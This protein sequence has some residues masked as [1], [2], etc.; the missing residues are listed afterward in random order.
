MNIDSLAFSLRSIISGLHKTLRK[1]MPLDT[2]L[3]LT[4]LETIGLISR[5]G[6]ML[7]SELALHTKIT[8]PSMS[9]ILKKMEKGG[10]IQKKS[11]LKDRRKILI[12]LTALGKKKVEE[13]QASKN[14]LIKQLI[15][16]KLTTEEIEVL[17][18]AVPILQK[19]NSI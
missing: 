14:E 12:S 1:K 17:K 8:M 2:A 5:N 15:Q 6:S 11:S 9:Q 4:E 18:Q 7:P 3:S 10:I 19:L 13:V 16:T